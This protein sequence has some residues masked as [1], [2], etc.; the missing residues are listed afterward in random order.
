MGSV[1]VGADPPQG[2]EGLILSADKALAR[3]RAEARKAERYV[4]VRHEGDGSSLLVAR[5][6]TAD[7][8]C[9]SRAIDTIAGALVLEGRAEP[10]PELRSEALAE[11]ARPSERGTL[12]Y[13]GSTLVVRVGRETGEG[14]AREDT[15]GPLLLEQ[16]RELLAHDR[17]RL[18][19]VIDLAGDPGAD[20]YEVPTRIREQV[21]IRDPFSVFPFS[22]M[23]SMN[24]DLDH[25]GPFR[26]R[27]LVDHD[28]PPPRQTRPSN[29]G[30][31]GRLEHRAKSHGR[32]RVSQT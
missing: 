4:Y 5:M 26:D 22:T 14:V 15:V 24:A 23:R 27:R 31:L 3:R 32:W 19:P 16:V 7:A 29:L 30:P 8:V 13:R 25:T 10:L 9:L 20:G 6:G 12:P 2:S 18:L 21:R 17:V 1:G 28:H 11:L